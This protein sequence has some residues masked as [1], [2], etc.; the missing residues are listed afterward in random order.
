MR[1]QVKIMVGGGAINADFARSIGG[2]IRRAA[3]V[4]LAKEPIKA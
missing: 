3:G 2:W 4:T 1:D